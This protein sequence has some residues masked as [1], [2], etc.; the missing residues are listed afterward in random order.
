MDKLLIFN[1]YKMLRYISKHLLFF[2]TTTRDKKPSLSVKTRLFFK[3][4]KKKIFALENK[5]NLKIFLE[6]EV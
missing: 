5:I 2:D 4:L 3:Q 6:F 1:F